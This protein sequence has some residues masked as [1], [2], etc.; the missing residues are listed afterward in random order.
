MN[1]RSIFEILAEKMGPEIPAMFRL[2]TKEAGTALQALPDSVRQA[3][4]YGLP[5]TKLPQEIY[6]DKHSTPP[7]ID[8]NH[9]MEMQM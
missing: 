9:E 8:R 3:D 5:W 7:S 6:N 4:E 2:G 1:L